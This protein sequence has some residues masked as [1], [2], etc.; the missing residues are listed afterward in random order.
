MRTSMSVGA[1]DVPI[2][3]DNL[4]DEIGIDDDMLRPW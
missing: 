1:A 2:N 4:W 3:R